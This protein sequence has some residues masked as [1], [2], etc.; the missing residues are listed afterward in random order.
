MPYSN[1][2]D[3]QN[4]LTRHLDRGRL[5]TQVNSQVQ[6]KVY[7]KKIEDTK[8]IFNRYCYDPKNRQYGM[9][10]SQG[11]NSEFGQGNIGIKHLSGRLNTAD[12]SASS[13]RV[14]LNKKLTKTDRVETE[15]IPV[16]SK[17]QANNVVTVSSLIG[18]NQTSLNASVRPHTGATRAA[19][20][21]N[22]N[23][24]IQKNED[25]GAKR[26]QSGTTTPKPGTKL[27]D[28]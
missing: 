28:I 17:S 11:Y 20:L 18:Q 2:Q 7:A 5:L 1:E 6:G 23:T 16:T 14:K 12:P 24:L 22:I 15:P 27:T 25:G 3:Y 8:R 9:T 26:I 13:P 10:I 4:L 19:V 21:N